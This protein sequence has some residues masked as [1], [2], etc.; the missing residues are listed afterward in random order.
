MLPILTQT[1]SINSSLGSSSR[2]NYAEK[3]GRGENCVDLLLLI[4]LIETS[5]LRP[6]NTLGRE[7]PPP[8]QSP[9]VRSALSIFL[10][11]KNLAPQGLTSFNTNCVW[12]CLES[13]KY[14][15]VMVEI[16]LCY[17]K[18]FQSYSVKNGPRCTEMVISGQQLPQP[19]S[20]YSITSSIV[21]VSCRHFVKI[22]T[23]KK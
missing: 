21:I 10:L 17:S 7:I 20:L 18:Y 1:H 14:V 13:L 15:T 8:F 22:Y 12:D 3:R 23:V 5:T 9:L 19:S 16:R 11:W 2:S 4:F 6:G